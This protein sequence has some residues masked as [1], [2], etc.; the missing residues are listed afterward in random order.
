MGLTSAFTYDANGWITNLN[1]P[2][3]NT[4]FQ[5]TGGTDN[6]LLSDNS[7]NRAIVVTEPNGKRQM[8]MYR[9]LCSHLTMDWN[10]PVLMAAS[11][12]ASELPTNTPINT[13]ENN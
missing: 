8:Y 4:S 10:S 12:P 5:F 9:Q 13:L 6:S 1:T 7:V 2:Y 11:F 3:G